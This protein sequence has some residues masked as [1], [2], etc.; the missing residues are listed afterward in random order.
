[1]NDGFQSWQMIVAVVGVWLSVAFAV[2]LA[3]A[4]IRF[5]RGW[6]LLTAGGDRRHKLGAMTSDQEFL[7]ADRGHDRLAR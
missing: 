2:Y 5:R 7:T 4:V 3:M 1:M 6:R